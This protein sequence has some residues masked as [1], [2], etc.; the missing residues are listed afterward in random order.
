MR[1]RAAAGARRPL[2]QARA[3]EAAEDTMSAG[4]GWRFPTQLRETTVVSFGS[5]ENS[6]DIQITRIA[7]KG[8]FDV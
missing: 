1:A 5:L 6:N 2:A 3:A 4:L 7:E 8:N